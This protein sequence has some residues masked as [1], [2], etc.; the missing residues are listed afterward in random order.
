MIHIGKKFG[1]TDNAVRKRCKRFG[2]DLDT[3]YS[4]KKKAGVTKLAAVT[5]PEAVG[6]IPMGVQVSPPAPSL[7]GG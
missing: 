2:I 5:V 1:V 7:T 6:I 3:P 4:K